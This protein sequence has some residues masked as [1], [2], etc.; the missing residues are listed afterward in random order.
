M[1]EQDFTEYTVVTEF[2]RYAFVA[3]VNRMRRDGWRLQGNLVVGTWIDALLISQSFFAQAMVK[4]NND[5]L[6]VGS[7]AFKVKIP[8]NTLYG[9]R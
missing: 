2:E 9:Q 5:E 4:G 3:E 1:C 8:E 6:V 7:S